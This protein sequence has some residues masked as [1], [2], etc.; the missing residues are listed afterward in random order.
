MKEKNRDRTHLNVCWRPI[1]TQHVGNQSVVHNWQLVGW[2]VGGECVS[3]KKGRV[4]LT[5]KVCSNEWQ[6][7]R[8]RQG[9]HKEPSLIEKFEEKKLSVWSSFD[10]LMFRVPRG[11]WFMFMFW[12]KGG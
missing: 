6:G 3:L 8:V 9:T 10:W 2:L 11:C 7:S 1:N 4:E 5:F 12:R